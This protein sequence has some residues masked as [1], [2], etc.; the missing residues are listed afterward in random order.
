LK[1]YK[2]YYESG[3]LKEEILYANGL[4]TGVKKEYFENGK[5]KREEPYL[6]WVLNGEVKEFYESGKLKR[7]VTYIQ[8]DSGV[9]VSFD[10]NGKEIK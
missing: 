8:G 5:L 6:D 4:I 7:K 1:D 2:E 9:T 3:Q 10:E